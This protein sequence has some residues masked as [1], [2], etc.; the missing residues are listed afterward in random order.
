MAGGEWEPLLLG[1]EPRTCRVCSKGLSRDITFFRGGWSRCTVCNQ[2]VHYSCLAS[3]TV[4]FL[5]M[6]PRVCK[7][8]R[9]EQARSGAAGAASLAVQS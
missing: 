8:C 5:K 6:R 7:V 3:G 1:I 9:E 2:F 4:K